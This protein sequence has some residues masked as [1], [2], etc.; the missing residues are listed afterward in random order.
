M[1]KVVIMKASY[2]F[3]LLSL[4]VGFSSESPLNA[5][6]PKQSVRQVKLPSQAYLNYTE[7]PVN[8]C[9]IQL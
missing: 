3:V 7:L 9:L 2:E 6:P 4:L 5:Q 8:F 1:Q